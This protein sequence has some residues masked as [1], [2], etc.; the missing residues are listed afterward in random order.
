MNS[1]EQLDDNLKTADVAKPDMLS[2]RESAVFDPVIAILRESYKIPC[3]G[4]N[5]CM[6]CPQ[7]VNIPGCFAAYNA[8]YAVGFASGMQQYFTSTGINRPGKNAGSRHCV[9]CGAC[10]QKCPQRIKVIREMDSVLK[11]M[12]PFWMRPIIRLIGKIIS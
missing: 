4:C 2:S 12:E 9:K 3:T 6:P 11:R 8:S 10:E 5:Y 7:G 1:A